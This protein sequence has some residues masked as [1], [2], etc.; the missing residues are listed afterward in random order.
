MQGIDVILHKNKQFTVQNI[1]DYKVI[2][3]E[4]NSTTITVHFPEEYENYSKR[5]DF[6]NI[7]GE[8]WT[9][10]L[11][12]PEEETKQYDENFDKNNF[13]FTLPRQVTIK[14]ELKIQFI[15]YLTDES[16][17]FV[18]F[19][20]LKI[21]VKDD[22]MYVK[23]GASDNPDLIVKAYENSNKALEL[24]R[25]AFDKIDKAEKDAESAKNSA[26]TA[27]AS[28]LV[29]KIKATAAQTSAEN[30]ETSAASAKAS[31]TSAANSA[32]QASNIS[33]NALSVA[34]SANSKSSSA[35]T[36]ANN[37]NKNSATALENSTTAKTNSEQALATSNFSLEKSEQAIAT[38]NEAKEISSEALEQVVDK[39]GTKVF[40]GSNDKPESNL[41]FS[42]NPQDQIDEI[43]NN[44][45][46]IK[47]DSGGF[48][49][50]ENSVKEK[51]FNFRG[52][53]LCDENGKIPVARLFDA[54]YPVGSIYIST[55]N[56]NPGILFGG[57]WEA[58][59]QGR[60]LVGNGTSDQQFIAG[61]TGGESNHTLTVKE[62]P[63]HTH[64]QNSHSHNNTISI[65]AHSHT[66]SVKTRNN[67]AGISKDYG[68]NGDHFCGQTGGTL[69]W[70]SSW[71]RTDDATPS[72]S[73]TNAS[74]TATNQN[75]GGGESHNNL[76]PYIVTYIWRRTS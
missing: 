18:P 44:T 70:T 10:A 31:A 75:T 41:S 17:S 50:G 20:L 35:V 3:S 66:T 5:V 47:N 19:E 25:E 12:I 34:N 32:Q 40:L 7:K 27:N 55:N 42:S 26:A 36:T 69:V 37:A 23:K 58:Y 48:S 49:C 21:D 52:F 16:E 68:T 2:G 45:T 73:I 43:K 61:S 14:G 9:I 11:Y 4:N 64:T 46:A 30:A 15:A 56:T 63:S 60:T 62:M 33:S 38:A 59:A 74:S 76:Q 39:M 51:G 28:A 54:I 57:N 72:Y 65:G 8:K 6:K 53:T 22:I 67:T 29:A 24:S 13:S 1:E 71:S